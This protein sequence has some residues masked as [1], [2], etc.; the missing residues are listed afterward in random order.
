M[1]SSNLGCLY[2]K[3]VAEKVK[4]KLTWTVPLEVGSSDKVDEFLPNSVSLVPGGGGWADC[5]SGGGGGSKVWLATWSFGGGPGGGG[6]S[7]TPKLGA[8]GFGGIG[9]GGGRG[10]EVGRTEL[11][12]EAKVE[13]SGKGGGGGGGGGG[14]AKAASSDSVFEDDAP[15][16]KGIRGPA[17]QNQIKVK[18]HRHIQST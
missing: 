1:C 17:C 9:G 8:G 7:E 12:P 13:L 18:T 10:K 6:G 14:T 4:D 2:D 15:A 16:D 11:S 3:A 5:W